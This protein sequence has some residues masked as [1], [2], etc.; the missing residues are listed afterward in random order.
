M[1]NVVPVCYLLC[2]SH[3]GHL[4]KSLL[5]GNSGCNIG[6]QVLVKRDTF[7]RHTLEVQVV[8]LRPPGWFVGPNLGLFGAKILQKRGLGMPAYTLGVSKWL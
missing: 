7:P 8:T 3:V 1:E 6:V 4:K 2:F 5:C